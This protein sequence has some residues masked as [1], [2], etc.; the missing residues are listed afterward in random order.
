MIKWA[1]K[2]ARVLDFESM[3]IATLEREGSGGDVPYVR[4]S[5]NPS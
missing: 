1:I 3:S 4:H 2:R 5:S